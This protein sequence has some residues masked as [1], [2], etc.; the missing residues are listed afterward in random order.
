MQ[1]S[2][3]SYDVALIGGG[4]AGLSLSILLAKANYRVALF[5]KE[6]FPFHKVCGE[7][8][9]LESWNFLEELGVCLSD[10]NLPVI[11][12]LM[13]SSPNGKYLQQ[14]LPLGGFGISRYK[15]DAALAQIAMA[16]GV[17]LYEQHKVTDVVNEESL[18]HIKN[19]AGIC[20]AKIVCGS[21]G[22][23]SNL[24]VKWKRNFTLTKSDKL[25]NYIGV[26]YH[27]RTNHPIDLIALHNF[28][29]GYCG[30]SQI[31]E[32]KYCLCYL[33]TA[34]NLRINDSSIEKMER[35][36]LQK[37]PFLKK[38]FTESTFLFPEPITI[39]QISFEKKM[40]VENNVMFL[41]DAAGM[42]TPLCGNGMSMALHAADIA[43]HGIDEFL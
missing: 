6:K 3:Q 37:N 32:N 5:E 18:F 17:R 33:T 28:K 42:I 9:S 29:N 22:K 19:S 20:Y 12:R 7:Y 13:V 43:F 2:N 15:L 27:I 24:D 26:K 35:N 39:S 40:Q 38:I 31:E 21:F 34:E 11:G 25:N 16:N 8:I 14:D 23:K 36:V 41:G 4:L 30:I 10:W 1:H